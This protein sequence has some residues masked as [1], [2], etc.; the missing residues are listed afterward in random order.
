MGNPVWTGTLLAI[1]PRK[2]QL[3]QATLE[4]ITQQF[5]IIA[6]KEQVGSD[7]DLP[8]L[9]YFFKFALSLFREQEHSASLQ[10]K[11]KI[12]IKK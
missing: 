10:K 8:S 5:P 6:V 11:N 2:F 7:N 3:S 12:I 1:T 4:E 9:S